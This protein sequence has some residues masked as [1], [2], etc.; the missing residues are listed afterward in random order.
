MRLIFTVVISIHFP[1]THAR[2]HTYIQR[3]TDTEKKQK[4]QES[5]TTVLLITARNKHCV[6]P[7][8]L[9]ALGAVARVNQ[10]IYTF[11]A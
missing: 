1:L 9:V 8:V 6:L 3:Y 11:I 5:T 10:V 2:A 7:F 4:A